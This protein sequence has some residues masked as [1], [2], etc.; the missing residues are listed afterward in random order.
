MNCPYWDTPRFP[1]LSPLILQEKGARG[2]RYLSLFLFNYNIN[3]AVALPFTVDATTVF[4]QIE[5]V[6]FAQLA[7]LAK[8]GPQVLIEERYPCFGSYL[9]PYLT[10]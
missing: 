9:F 1:L 6:F 7:A 10:Q 8:A 3:V 5:V 2:M 4:L